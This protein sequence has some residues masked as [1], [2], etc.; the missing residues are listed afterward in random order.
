IPPLVRVSPTSHG[1]NMASRILGVLLLSA[2]AVSAQTP[3]VA[4]V[5]VL[6]AARLFDG[7]G[8]SAVRDG[9]VIVEGGKIQAVGAGLAA[10]AGAAVIDLGDATLL[11]GF[12][13]AHTHLTGESSDNWYESAMNDLRR[14]VPEKAIR[15]TEYAL[16]TLQAGF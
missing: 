3:P 15:A 2:A 9:V 4:E 14:G 5:T 1:G 8:D 7:K 10:P 11:P 16:R 6:K 12:I 13:D